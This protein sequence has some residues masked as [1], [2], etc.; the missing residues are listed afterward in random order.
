MTIQIKIE[1]NNLPKVRK[2]ISALLVM[3][4]TLEKDY[5]NPVDTEEISNTIKKKSGTRKAPAKKT[6]TAVKDVKEVKPEPEPVKEVKAVKTASD[7]ISLE[8]LTQV[9]RDSVAKAGRDAVRTLVEIHSDTTK[10][11]GVPIENY[12][13]LVAEL[14]AL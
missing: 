14:K 3:V 6:E 7:T 2:E 13:V 5:K 8:E 4:D 11:S 10:L 1:L 12:S 9:A